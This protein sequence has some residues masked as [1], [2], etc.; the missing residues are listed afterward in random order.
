MPAPSFLTGSSTSNFEY[1]RYLAT[2]GEGSN[3]DGKNVQIT[4]VDSPLYIDEVSNTL[5]YL[6]YCTVGTVGSVPKFRLKKIEK[7]GTVTHISYP[8]ADRSFIYIWDN[9]LG[10]TYK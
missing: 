10:Y 5:S 6:G 4:D 9:R 1:Y 2:P 7:I 3:A 8:N